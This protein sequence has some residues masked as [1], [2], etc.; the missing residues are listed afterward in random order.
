M[1]NPRIELPEIPKGASPEAIIAAIGANI[2]DKP[3]HEETARNYVIRCLAALG[4]ARTPSVYN[5]AIEGSK[6]RIYK[7]EK[8]PVGDVVLATGPSFMPKFVAASALVR[9]AGPGDIYTLA[10]PDTSRTAQRAVEYSQSVAAR[11]ESRAAQ[12]VARQTVSHVKET[13]ERTTPPSS[14]APR[15][16][17]EAVSPPPPPPA[18]AAPPAPS[19][20]AAERAELKNFMASLLG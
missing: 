6:V 18:A 8:T 19:G 16:P 1:N 17:R 9:K 2:N 15:A 10:T 3:V 12:A 20:E 13:L 7:W 14:R 4:S 11:T 5:G